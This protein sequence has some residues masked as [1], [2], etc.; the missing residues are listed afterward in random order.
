MSLRPPLKWAGGKR[1]LVPELKKIWQKHKHQRLVEPF[2]GGLAVT[3]GLRPKLALL[4]DINPHLINFYKQLQSGFDA[5][6]MSE[7]YDESIYYS[8][9]DRFND[10]IHAGDVNTREM[11]S[12]FYYMNRSCFNGLCRFNRKGEFNVPFGRYPKVNYLSGDD[13]QPYQTAF[14]NWTFQAGDF[15]KVELL[16]DDFLYADPPY[17]VEFTSYAKQ[18]FTWDDQI[19]LIS[20]LNQHTGPVIISNQATPRIKDLYRDNG[21]ELI[22]LKAPRRISRTGDRTP[23]PEILAFRNIS[24]IEKQEQLKLF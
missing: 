21:Y 12:L 17:D 22:E 1:W 9:R 6:F 16:P 15:E 19:R 10:N 4:N 5:Q 23:A 13:W 11:A 18:D 2:C 8:R 3:L 7:E 20:W 24:K 14:K